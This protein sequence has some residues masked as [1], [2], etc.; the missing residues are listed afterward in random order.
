M[1]ND[2]A[3]AVAS[4]SLP[5]HHQT[6]IPKITKEI[7]WQSEQMY[8]LVVWSRSL[9]GHPLDMDMVSMKSILNLVGLTLIHI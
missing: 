5:F 3:W 8:P 9:L 2:A 1:T 6:L 4:W 7:S